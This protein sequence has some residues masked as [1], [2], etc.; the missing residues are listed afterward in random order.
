MLSSL[1]LVSLLIVLTHAI[2]LKDELKKEL[3][4]LERKIGIPTQAT[5]FCQSTEATVAVTF[6]SPSECTAYSVIQVVGG[7]QGKSYSNCS[8]S[9]YCM[10]FGSSISGSVKGFSVAG[11]SLYNVRGG[12]FELDSSATCNAV[13]TNFIGEYLVA[14][15]NGA[16]L[17]LSDAYSC[18]GSEGAASFNLPGS[19]MSVTTYNLMSC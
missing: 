15:C 12:A 4:E 7:P 18:G 5:A 19:N 17:V 14:T 16:Q 9:T 11:V 2:S 3:R 10:T 13:Q 1:Y 6:I 8:F